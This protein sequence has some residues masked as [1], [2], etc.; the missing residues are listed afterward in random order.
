MTSYSVTS[1]QAK[2]FGF[3]P[4]YGWD[5]FVFLH[6]EIASKIKIETFPMMIEAENVEQKIRQKSRE[7]LKMN[8]ID[9]DK[10]IAQAKRRRAELEKVV[11][12]SVNLEFKRGRDE[13]SKGEEMTEDSMRNVE[14]ELLRKLAKYE[15]NKN[16]KIDMELE[17]WKEMDMEIY[18]LKLELIYYVMKEK[19]DGFVKIL[20]SLETVSD[21]K[22]CF[23]YV[24]WLKSI[25]NLTLFLVT[26]VRMLLTMSALT[27]SARS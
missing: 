4:K 23:R 5:A 9:A 15:P 2:L 22:K 1:T 16:D 25:A 19:L 8:H 17:K 26:C 21:I 13:D 10:F 14:K 27:T 12:E 20:D 24:F 3:V 11:S 7:I 6:P 18:A